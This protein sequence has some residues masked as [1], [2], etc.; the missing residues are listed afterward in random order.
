MSFYCVTY[1]GI[2]IY[3]V[4]TYKG[5]SKLNTCNWGCINLLCVS[6]KNVLFMSTLNL[7]PPFKKCTSVLW[8]FLKSLQTESWISSHSTEGICLIESGQYCLPMLY[9]FS[10]VL[11]PVGEIKSIFAPFSHLSH[12]VVLSK[13]KRRRPSRGTLLASLRASHRAPLAADEITADIRL[14][15]GGG[16]MRCRWSLIA[17]VHLVRVW[18]YACN[19]CAGHLQDCAVSLA[20]GRGERSPHLSGSTEDLEWRHPAHLHRGPQWKG[21]HSH[22]LHKVKGGLLGK[23]KQNESF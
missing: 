18:L 20:D 8:V 2:C 11:C 14:E 17:N 23:E 16:H 22:R 13:R 10:S 21:R 15:F 4:H 19:T 1:K 9:N 6:Q 7:W 12:W 5:I 3:K